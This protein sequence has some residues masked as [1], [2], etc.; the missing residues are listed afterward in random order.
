MKSSRFQEKGRSQ[1]IAA[2]VC[3]PPRISH[4]D[5]ITPID[6][7]KLGHELPAKR[8]TAAAESYEASGPPFETFFLCVLYAPP[9]DLRYNH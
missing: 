8:L 2:K 5:W 7:E 1:E 3:P 4:D 9:L 6:P